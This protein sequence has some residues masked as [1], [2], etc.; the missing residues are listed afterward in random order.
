TIQEDLSIYM[1][2]EPAGPRLKALL[3]TLDWS[4]DQPTVDMIVGLNARLQRQIG[5]VSRMETGV[6][7]PEE[8]LETAKGSC[9]DTSWL[10]VQILRHLG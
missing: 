5:Y 7:T 8:T 3:P 9:L 1:T 4:P 10:L 2:P 6:Q